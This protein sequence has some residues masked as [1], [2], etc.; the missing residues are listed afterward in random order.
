MA[1]P[2]PKADYY[3]IITRDGVRGHEALRN[4]CVA[5]S[6]HT[7]LAFSERELRALARRLGAD[8]AVAC[9]ADGTMKR[10]KL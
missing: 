2:I 7:H 10:I 5:N 8:T 3:K 4:R 1:R 9:Y 6:V